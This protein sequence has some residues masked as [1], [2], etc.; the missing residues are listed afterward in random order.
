MQIMPVVLTLYIALNIYTFF[1]YYRDKFAAANNLS[2]TPEIKLHVLSLM[3]GWQGAL[4]AIY[5]LRHKRQKFEFM[6]VYVVTVILNLM[7]Y[8]VIAKIVP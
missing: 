5:F 7:A 1:S 6:V 3:G 4:L 8:S 2:R